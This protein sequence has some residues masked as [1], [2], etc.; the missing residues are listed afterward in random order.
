MNIYLAY[1]ILVTFLSLEFDYF[2]KKFNNLILNYQSPRK[3]TF[4]NSW[5]LGFFIFRWPQA[6]AYQLLILILLNNKFLLD[7]F[8]KDFI[9]KEDSLKFKNFLI[10][11][12]K[13][14]IL[15]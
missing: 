11:L 6:P 13:V 8:F 1:V 7:I 15:I 2:L 14:S 3:P 5:R 10:I 4:I 12:K 9:I